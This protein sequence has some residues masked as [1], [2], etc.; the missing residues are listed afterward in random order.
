M[1]CDHSRP[2]ATAACTMGR[3][4]GRLTFLNAFLHFLHMNAISI[5]R[6]SLWSA[7]SASVEAAYRIREGVGQFSFAE[8]LQ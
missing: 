1:R 6:A 4:R 3:R 7:R 2:A 8:M 5:V